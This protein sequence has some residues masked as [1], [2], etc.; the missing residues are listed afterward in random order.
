[1]T[2]YRRI[3]FRDAQP[4][5]VLTL[6]D[7]D[8][9]YQRTITVQSTE[10]NEVSLTRPDGSPLDV[11][12]MSIVTDD[13]YLFDEVKLVGPDYR[14]EPAWQVH[15]VVEDEDVALREDLALIAEQGLPL[16]R[17][18][19]EAAPFKDSFARVLTVA[20]AAVADGRA[21]TYDLPQYRDHA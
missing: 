17:E 11:S 16:D 13:S 4:G 6:A 3:R 8:G 12:F 7:S 10:T 5:D 9:D 20:R 21:W 2:V 19:P 18:D 14:V 1:M 15:K